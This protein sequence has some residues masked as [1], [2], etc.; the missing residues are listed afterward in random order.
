M[1]DRELNRSLLAPASER[2][3]AAAVAKAAGSDRDLARWRAQRPVSVGYQRITGMFVT[4][5]NVCMPHSRHLDA[6][7]G[8]S[9]TRACSRSEAR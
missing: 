8:W 6:A 4:R 7:E 3:A 5:P 9:L 1:Y 2:R